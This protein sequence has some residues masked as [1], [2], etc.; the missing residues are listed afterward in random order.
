MDQIAQN[1]RLAN[2]T[3]E[4]SIPDYWCNEYLG[5]TAPSTT[6]HDL[7]ERLKKG[8]GPQSSLAGHA[9]QVDMESENPCGSRDSLSG[10]PF[11]PSNQLSRLASISI[12]DRFLLACHFTA[13]LKTGEASS[14]MA[15][16]R[17]HGVSPSW[18]RSICELVRLAP[19]I[20]ESVDRMN[21]KEANARVGFRALFEISQVKSHEKQRRR[22]EELTSCEKHR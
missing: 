22:F 1:G 13:Q 15:L 19:E 8:H 21:E 6:I 11:G 5:K 18:M 17:D 10:H 7:L 4:E 3:V 14:Q 9:H 12:H 20:Q 16:A 2:W